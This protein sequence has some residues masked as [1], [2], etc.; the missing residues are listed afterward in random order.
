MTTE[1]YSIFGTGI[2]IAVFMWG[3]HANSEARSDKAHEAI[4]G[5]IKRLDLKID[6]VA[7]D[8][9]DLKTDVAVLKT[10]MDWVKNTFQERSQP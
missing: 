8:M 6:G 1:L 10:D 3:L 9:A 4:G 5:N 2:A 7:K